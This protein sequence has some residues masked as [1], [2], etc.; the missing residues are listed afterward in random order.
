MKHSSRY[1]THKNE[2]KDV[3]V[4]QSKIDDLNQELEFVKQ[5]TNILRHILK[6][7]TQ[8]LENL[9]KSDV[10]RESIG[11]HTY[12]DIWLQL[13]T[14]LKESMEILKRDL[15][16][17]M[18]VDEPQN[19]VDCIT[20]KTNDILTAIDSSQSLENWFER[21]MDDLALTEDN[22]L[23]AL[24]KINARFYTQ[25]DAIHKSLNILLE[26]CLRINE[27]YAL[28]VS[29]EMS[30]RKDVAS[31]VSHL[32]ALAEEWPTI[33]LPENAT[34]YF[35]AKKHMITEW[36]KFFA[37]VDRLELDQIQS[38]VDQLTRKVEILSEKR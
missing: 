30:W 24:E 7:L 13:R 16:K 17:E 19:V 33:V 15:K 28:N 26:E 4:S 34:N 11:S 22:K 37:K 2:G 6:E 20:T 27:F 8:K 12:S 38:L 25:L 35:V 21:Q 10:N 5:W 14:K 36:S 31:L 32:Q 1:E 9:R 18:S 3:L 29:E 23:E